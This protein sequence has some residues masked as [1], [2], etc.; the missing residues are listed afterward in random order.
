MNDLPAASGDPHSTHR[1]GT[2]Y[3]IPVNLSENFSPEAI[4]PADVIKTALSLNHYIAENAK[5]ARAFLKALGIARP[6]AEVSIHELDK[7]ASPSGKKTNPSIDELLQPLLAG[8]PLGLVS[9]AGAPAVAD[10]GALVVAAAHRAGIRVIPL[11]G[12]SSILLALMAAGLNGQRFA[13]HGYLPQDSAQRIKQIHTLE[14]ESRQH[15]MTQLFIETP[16]RNQATLHDLLIGLSPQTMLCIASDLTGA[17]ESVRTMAIAEWR[18]K[19]VVIAKVPT[20]F[21]F[22]A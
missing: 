5:T 16:Y 1:T 21:L 3:L 17:N 14:R 9:E 7:H 6:L 22:L 10:P 18:K 2:L 12:P 8:N 19:N 4:L 20:L 11:V 13:F 15:G